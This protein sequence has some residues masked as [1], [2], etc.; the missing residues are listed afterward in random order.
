VWTESGASV[1]P[2]NWLEGTGMRRHTIS[3]A[4]WNRV[5]GLLPDRG[6]KADNRRFVN[7][8]LW[9][10]RTGCPWR[11]L[12]G[13]FGNWNSVWRRFRRWAAAGVW[14][15]VLAA[16]RDPDVSTLILDSTVVRAHPAAAGAQKKS[17]P[18]PSAA[19][20]GGGGRR[21]TPAS[22]AGGTRWSSS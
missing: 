13:R 15:R 9:V 7:A 2:S 19:A 17:A 10:A 22:T 8:I 18:R 3:T 20:A 16:V 6:P 12:P 5:K 21:P 11:D 1:L 14:G 4:D